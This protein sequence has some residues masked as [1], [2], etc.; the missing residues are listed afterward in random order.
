MIEGEGVRDFY[1][2][3]IMEKTQ[4]LLINVGLLKFYEEA[5]SLKGNSRL[6]VQLIHQWDFPRQALC[7][8]PDMWHEPIGEEIY[9]ITGLSTRGGDFPQFLDVP[10]RVAVKSHLIYSQRYIVDH[11]ISPMNFPMSSG[12]L[13]IASFG[14]E[15]FRCLSLLV[16]TIS[17]ST[18]VWKCISIPLL[19][20]LIIWCRGH[21]VSDGLPLF[22]GSFCIDS[23]RC[24]VVIHG[25]ENFPFS[26]ELFCLFFERFLEMMPTFDHSPP[27]LITE[28]W[29]HMQG[30]MIPKREQSE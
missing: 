7:V 14:A 21:D 23:D 5:T 11:V 12:Q 13:Q 9:F 15:D 28:V 1:P 6:L 19:F 24:F 27:K 3:H 26:L 10:N 8:S 22:C 18:S 17:H 30:E 20:M 25:R 2:H 16:N 4:G 29:M